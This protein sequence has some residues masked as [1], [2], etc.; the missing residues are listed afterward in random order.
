MD[1]RICAMA[2]AWILYQTTNL[3]NFKIYVGVHK[4]ADTPRSRQYLGSGDRLRAAIKKYGTKNFARKTL[5]EF[6]CCEDVYK[7]EAEL[8]NQAFVDREDTYNICLGGRGGV[9]FTKEM[10]AK[11]SESH[12]GKTHGAEARAK[13]SAFNKGKVTSE[14]TKAKIGAAHKGKKLPPHSEKTKANKRAATTHLSLPVVINGAYYSSK[15]F[16]A[17]NEN[18]YIST[19]INRVKSNN[20]KWVE[21]RLATESEKL[22]HASGEVQ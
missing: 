13:I 8:V 7:A 10:K 2:E 20:P 15:N 4:V 11:L 22:V 3:L 9:N 17:K 16:A 12:K 18:V 5:A 14:E 1:M 6:S 21:W 19:L